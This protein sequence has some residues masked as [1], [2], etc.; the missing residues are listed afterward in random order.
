MIPSRFKP[1]FSLI[2]SLLGVGLFAVVS[3]AL[4][5]FTLTTLYA[6]DNL[7]LQ[8]RAQNIAREGIEIME[9]LRGTNAISHVIWTTPPQDHPLRALQSL[10]KF[11]SLSRGGEVCVT[12]EPL[13][14]G[15]I[16]WKIEPFPCPPENQPYF[17]TNTELFENTDTNKQVFLT[18]NQAGV[19]KDMFRYIR[20]R[21]AKQSPS[22]K[23]LWSSFK[24]T[25]HQP[26]PDDDIVEVDAVVSWKNHGKAQ[27][28]QLQ[29]AL[30]DWY[31]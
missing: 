26:R 18:H 31:E 22:L 15:Y 30:A 2:D 7:G 19:S 5:Q 9:N 16:P 23:D 20:I 8:L 4:V 1:G 14:T 24:D 29:K 21:L 3:V 13:I 10:M 28:M 25:R 17:G 27:E 11:D 12:V 6:A